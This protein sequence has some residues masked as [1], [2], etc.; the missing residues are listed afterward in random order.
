MLKWGVLKIS[1]YKDKSLIYSHKSIFYS[2]IEM[3]HRWRYM[4]LLL[5]NLNRQI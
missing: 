5:P 3:S 4:F 2:Y 1:L